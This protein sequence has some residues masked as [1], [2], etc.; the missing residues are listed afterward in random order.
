MCTSFSPNFGK[1]DSV[2]SCAPTILQL[3][4]SKLD[5]GCLLVLT[6]S[7]NEYMQQVV[8]HHI[9]DFFPEIWKSQRIEFLPSLLRRLKAQSSCSCT[10]MAASNRN[11]NST[12]VTIS[13]KKVSTNFR[14]HAAFTAS[15]LNPSASL[16]IQVWP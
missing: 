11:G 6:K 2:T 7:G 13:K 5:I 4:I 10:R 1:K 16:W 8:H 14:G 9:S 12:K 15:V 3:R